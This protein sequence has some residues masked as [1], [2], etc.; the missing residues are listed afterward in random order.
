M[1][2]S[3]PAAVRI[4]D[5]L[6]RMGWSATTWQLAQAV[7]SVAVHSDVASVRAWLG[8]E[9][10]REPETTVTCTCDGRVHGR[11]IYRYCVRQDVREIVRAGLLDHP[12]RAAS[13]I[14]THRSEAA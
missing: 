12:E 4:L 8:A 6:R 5:A 1:H 9:G 2:Y 13:I 10:I 3:V 7:R 14:S 11:Q